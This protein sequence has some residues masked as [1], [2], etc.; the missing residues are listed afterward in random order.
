MYIRTA[1]VVRAT[2]TACAQIYVFTHI[3]IHIYTYIYEEMT[4]IND[5]YMQKVPQSPCVQLQW[6]AHLRYTRR[7]AGG[8]G[9]E[10]SRGGGT[11][12]HVSHDVARQRFSF[13]ISWVWDACHTHEQVM[14]HIYQGVVLHIC[15]CV[16]SK[17]CVWH[18]A[19][20]YVYDI[21]HVFDISCDTWV[22][23]VFDIM[24]LLSRNRT[25]VS[26]QRLIWHLIWYKSDICVWHHVIHQSFIY[27]RY[28]IHVSQMRH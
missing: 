4:I 7:K 10:G 18:D 8:R 13:P 12:S 17:T 24:C 25:R 23:H 2:S 20:T 5:V 26:H 28:V 15:E 1:I 22:I 9:K 16:M 19:L 11:E 21:N 3:Y 27:H 14:S 6:R